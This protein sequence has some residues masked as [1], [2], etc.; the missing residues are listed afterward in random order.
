MYAMNSKHKH[1]ARIDIARS[2]LVTFNL[3]TCNIVEPD[4]AT[5]NL[6]R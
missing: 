5:S 3:A 6:I 2:N 1:T 4:L